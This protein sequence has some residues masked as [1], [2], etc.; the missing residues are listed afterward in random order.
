MGS[1]HTALHAEAAPPFWEDCPLLLRWILICLR[2]FCFVFALKVN[3]HILHGIVCREEKLFY[4][5]E[6]FKRRKKG[7]TLSSFLPETMQ[8]EWPTVETV[9]TIM[10]ENQTTA[11]NALAERQC[12]PCSLPSK[13][14]LPRTQH[15]MASACQCDVTEIHWLQSF[16]SS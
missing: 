3:V 10:A 14:Q 9:F 15:H 7:A 8:Q 16:F 11:L 12:D 2:S 13:Q 5:T 1:Y 4:R 6:I